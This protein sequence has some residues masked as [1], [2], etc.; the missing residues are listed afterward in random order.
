[1]LGKL[2]VRKPLTFPVNETFTRQWRNVPALSPNVGWGARAGGPDAHCWV[3]VQPIGRACPCA[4]R[5]FFA[6][7]PSSRR[8]RQSN[9]AGHWAAA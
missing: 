3:G 7:C 5:L 2:D 9:V 6:N 1:M 4:V 8:G